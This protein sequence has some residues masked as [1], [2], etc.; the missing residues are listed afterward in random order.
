MY[1]TMIGNIYRLD[2]NDNVS[3]STLAYIAYSVTHDQPVSYDNLGTTYL[4]NNKCVEQ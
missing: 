2:L 3:L 4:R 1:I